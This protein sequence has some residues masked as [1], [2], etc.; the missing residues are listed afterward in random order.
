M[1]ELT[2]EEKER[3]RNRTTGMRADELLVSVSVIPTTVLA[4]ELERRDK[5]VSAKLANIRAILATETPETSI[6]ECQQIL[7][8]IK[9]IVS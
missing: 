4:Q 9:A 2:E 5:W 6:D 7:R 1:R 3:I 8:A